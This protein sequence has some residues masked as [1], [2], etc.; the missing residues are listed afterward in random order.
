MRGY[1]S[2]LCQT[3][4]RNC[5]RLPSASLSPSAVTGD[6]HSVCSPVSETE[7][8]LW[9]EPTVEAM[10]LWKRFVSSQYFRI[11]MITA[12]ILHFSRSPGPTT[13]SMDD[14]IYGKISS[15]TIKFFWSTTFFFFKFKSVYYAGRRTD[16]RDKKSRDFSGEIFRERNYCPRS[17]N[18]CSIFSGS[19]PC[20]I[21]SH[22]VMS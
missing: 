15:S 19:N 7:F 3:V 10:C 6:Q 21:L 5:T 16:F 11:T 17:S 13:L 18:P 8:F 22:P 2:L 4:Q 20:S 1:L 9:L 14:V 12:N